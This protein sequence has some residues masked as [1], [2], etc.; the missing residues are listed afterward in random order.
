MFST[1]KE[2]KTRAVA[3]GSVLF[4]LLLSLLLAA[5]SM[6]GG[7]VL[8]NFS[9]FPLPND[10]GAEAMTAGPDGNLWVTGYG[11]NMIARVTPKGEMTTF[12]IPTAESGAKFITSG[13]DGNLWFSE[14]Q[15]NKIGR[16]TPT[17][18]ITEFPIAAGISGGITAGP[19]G[20]LWFLQGTS[21]GR[22]TPSGTSTTF[23][24]PINEPFYNG[25]YGEGITVGP[26]GNIW[27]TDKGG[28]GRFSPNQ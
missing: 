3:C 18:T 4:F 1:R 20:N 2:S 10:L 27:V 24:K 16:I 17:G 9:D 8:T 7:N 28:I 12:P 6:P 11:S 15:A 23:A 19:D 13:P 14:Y 26:D 5:C 22:I 21:I 25:G